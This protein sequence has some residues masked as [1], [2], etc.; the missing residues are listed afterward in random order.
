MLIYVPPTPLSLFLFSFPSTNVVTAEK[1]MVIFCFGGG[2]K[3]FPPTLGID[4]ISVTF[5]IN[6]NIVPTDSPSKTEPSDTASCI[7]LRHF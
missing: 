1:D 2:K 7:V 3:I 4:L 5:R 6:L